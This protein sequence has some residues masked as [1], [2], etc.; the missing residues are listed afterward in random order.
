MVCASCDVKGVDQRL[1]AGGSAVDGVMKMEVSE[2]AGRVGLS[3]SRDGWPWA[4][5]DGTDGSVPATGLRAFEPGPTGCPPT[6]LCCRQ[7][8][9]ARRGGEF[10]GLGVCRLW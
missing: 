6:A 7:P 1:R 4:G 9:D 2:A 5:K 8:A 10:A 3:A